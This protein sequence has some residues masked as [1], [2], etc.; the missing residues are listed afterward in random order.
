M[1]SCPGTRRQVWNT[2][3]KRK[4]THVLSTWF[5]GSGC[6]FVGSHICRL[7]FGKKTC[8]IDGPLV[9]DYLIDRTSGC[10][11]PNPDSVNSFVP[12]KKFKKPVII[13][14]SSLFEQG[15]GPKQWT[16]VVNLT[17]I[18]AANTCG[19]SGRVKKV[20]MSVCLS[21]WWMDMHAR[22]T[23]KE[24]PADRWKQR[25][26]LIQKFTSTWDLLDLYT[27]SFTHSSWQLVHITAHD[28]AKHKYIVHEYTPNSF[29]RRCCINS[30]NS[31]VGGNFTAIICQKL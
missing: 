10:S 18:R 31:S 11:T 5:S 16:H 21:G 24:L 25:V 7:W 13:N 30:W 1:P 28:G 6:D 27:R 9:Q 19:L 12:T 22:A 14:M 8:W 29:S 4:Q 23:K 26:A 2:R 20:S 3:L 15:D 17:S